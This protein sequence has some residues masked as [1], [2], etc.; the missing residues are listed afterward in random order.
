MGYLSQDH[1]MEN[2]R[3]KHGLKMVLL[4]IAKH[5]NDQREH[6]ECWPST[7]RL[8]KL[9]GMSERNIPRILRELVRLK[10]IDVLEKG[11]GKR[12]TRYKLNIDYRESADAVGMTKCHPSPTQANKSRGDNLSLRGDNMSEGRTN[13][14]PSPDTMSPE[15]RIESRIESISEVVQHQPQNE[16]MH[17]QTETSNTVHKKTAPPSWNE[18]K[19]AL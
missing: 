2:V 10:Y 19:K 16:P 4:A 6:L 17:L 5:V 13:C 15:S 3:L 8:A 18:L 11:T 12:S 9:S 1:I 14:H 7:S